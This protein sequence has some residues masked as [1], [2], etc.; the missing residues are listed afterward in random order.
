MTVQQWVAMGLRSESAARRTGALLVKAVVEGGVFLFI[1]V[2]FGAS[3]YGLARL[4]QLDRLG[5]AV[6][7]AGLGLLAA[8]WIGNNAWCYLSE[9][10]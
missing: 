4:A 8:K 9:E 1:G 6:S 7:T 2:L 5:S 3:A 10:R